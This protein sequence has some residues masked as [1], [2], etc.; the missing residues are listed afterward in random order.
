VDI[1]EIFFINSSTQNSQRTTLGVRRKNRVQRLKNSAFSASLRERLA[2][3]ILNKKI[4]LLSYPVVEEEVTP[5]E[6]IGIE[7]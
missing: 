4:A 3:V 1:S 7:S 2:L 6:K 5:I